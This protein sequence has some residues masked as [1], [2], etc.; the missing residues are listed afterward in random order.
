MHGVE[1][2][3]LEAGALA[4]ADARRAGRRAPT[5]RGV[6]RWA[7]FLI[8]PP[9]MVVLGLGCWGGGVKTGLAGP[10]LCDFSSRLR[11]PGPPLLDFWRPDPRYA[12]FDQI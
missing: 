11:R 12:I 4:L 1:G 5:Q 3:T 9:P 10:P 6:K 7:R 2:C 8:A